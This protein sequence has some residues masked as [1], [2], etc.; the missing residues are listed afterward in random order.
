[1]RRHTRRGAL[2]AAALAFTVAACGGGSDEES[3]AGGAQ[4]GTGGKEATSEQENLSLTVSIVPGLPN[5]QILLGLEEG[6]FA[7]HGI[8]LTTEQVPNPAGGAAAVAGGQSDFAYMPTMPFY[9][10]ASEDLPI[11]IVAAGDGY[12]EGSITQ[13]A[14][15]SGERIDATAVM[16]AEDSS[17]QRPRDLEG[18]TVAVPGRKAQLEITVAGAVAEDGGDPEQIEFI[19]LPFPEQ[20]E[21]LEQGRIDAA[22]LIS[23]FIE[24]ADNAGARILAQP[25]AVVFGEGTVGIYVTTQERVEQEPEVVERFREA[26]YAAAE[27]ANDDPEAAR[28]AAAEATGQEPDAIPRLPTLHFWTEVTPGSLERSA[29]TMVELGYLDEMPDIEALVAEGA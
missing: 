23:P 19:A 29:E 11:R 1:M 4:D 3:A 2:A 28:A 24:A 21:A 6:V 18:T 14:I 13:E 12:A 7:E 10:A 25:G 17:L 27:I 8:D 26:V 20:V 9:V 22:S 15:D 16:V 5:A